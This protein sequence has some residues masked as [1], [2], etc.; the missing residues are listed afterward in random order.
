MPSNMTPAVQIASRSFFAV[1]IKPPPPARSIPIAL[2][3]ALV[4]ATLLLMLNER[5]RHRYGEESVDA[6]RRE[7]IGEEDELRQV[8]AIARGRQVEARLGRVRETQLVRLGE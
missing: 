6:S 5:L 1:R 8:A 4:A 7:E 2:S 3:A